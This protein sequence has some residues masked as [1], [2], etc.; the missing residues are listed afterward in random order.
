[1]A[2]ASGLALVLLG[3]LV[4]IVLVLGAFGLLVFGLVAANARRALKAS[5]VALAISVLSAVLSF[6][7]W[8]VV[9]SGRDTHGEPLGYP[10][11]WPLAA[12]VIIEA[13]AIAA[14]VWGIIRQR[15]RIR[16]AASQQS[17]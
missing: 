14:A 9:L 10:E 15:R 4:A 3:G 8:K 17:L 5:V 12:V 7:F 16:R 2:G 1:M 13:F 11:S 6:P